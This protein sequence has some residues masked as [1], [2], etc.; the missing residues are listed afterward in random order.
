MLERFYELKLNNTIRKFDKRGI[1]VVSCFDKIY[2]WVG[3]QV[4]K[5]LKKT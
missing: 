2:V 1:F 4:N 3:S 5:N